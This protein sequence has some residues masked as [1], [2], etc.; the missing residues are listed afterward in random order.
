MRTA[1]I[2][3][4]LLASG[5]FSE[6]GVAPTDRDA[7]ADLS[8]EADASEISSDSGA[9][10]DPTGEVSVTVDGVARLRPGTDVELTV[11]IERNGV[12]GA[13]AIEAHDLPSGVTVIS[14]GIEAGETDAVITVAA[15]TAAPIGGPTTATL[16]AS[17]DGAD[18]STLLTVV[19]AG[20]PGTADTSFGVNGV[21]GAAAAAG[22][23]TVGAVTVDERGRILVA[24]RSAAAST[25]GYVLA[26]SGDGR[27]DNDFGNR[28]MFTNFGGT[29]SNVVGGVRIDAFVLN[30]RIDGTPTLLRITPEGAI[31]DD[32]GTAPLAA[33][34]QGPVQSGPRAVVWAGPQIY[35]FADSGTPEEFSVT[36]EIGALT[37]D[38]EGRY[39][40]AEAGT[41]RVSR[42]TSDGD[43][44]V[45]FGA[46]GSLQLGG[47]FAIIS[48]TT[49]ATGAFAAAAGSSESIIAHFDHSGQLVPGFASSGVLMLGTDEPTLVLAVDSGIFVVVD[50]TPSSAVL[51]Y[52]PD[53][54]RDTRF[55]GGGEVT[56]DGATGEARLALDE[57]GGRLII[58]YPVGA[59]LEVRRYW[60]DTL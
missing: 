54:M 51:R 53:G 7:E 58:A 14:D 13:V 35:L 23:D 59:D 56:L 27:L 30:T 44:D 41:T 1:W 19:V 29:S 45:E 21:A 8:E 36:G 5:C 52:R 22:D 31:D 40:L 46:S 28:G 26:L 25:T 43:P 42:L 50:R 48:L 20:E 18:G 57:V 34:A 17:A 38:H 11:S 15:T 6:P 33:G 47:N 16:R 49:S 39:L 4:G 37:V 10:A 2:L 3:C 60:L 32:W 12:D 9:D 55:G 24:G